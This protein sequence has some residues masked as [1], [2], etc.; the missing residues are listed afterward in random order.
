M[1]IPPEALELE[2]RHIGSEGEPTLGE[3]FMVLRDEWREGNR[4]R[5]LCLHLLFLGWYGLI[6]PPFLTGF[7]GPEFDDV[8][9]LFAEVYDYVEPTI[10]TDAEML[11]VVGL[12]AHLFGFVLPGG[13]RV[14]GERADRFRLLYRKLSGNGID[15]NIFNDRGYFG[16]YYFHQSSVVDGY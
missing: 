14:W 7:E 10:E 12:G 8:Q 16:D 15:P 3:A 2:N 6:E 11:Y 5:E 13:E 1:P 9:G 4:D